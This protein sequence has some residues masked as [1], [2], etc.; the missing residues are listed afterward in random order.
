MTGCAVW[1]AAALSPTTCD[2]LCGVDYCTSPS[3]DDSVSTAPPVPDDRSLPLPALHMHSNNAAANAVKAAV[4][5]AAAAPRGAFMHPGLAGPHRLPI[6][7]MFVNAG[8]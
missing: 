1:W 4:S 8:V 7:D 5:A 2:R 6:A 3:V